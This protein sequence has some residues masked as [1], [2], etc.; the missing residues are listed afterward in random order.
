LQPGDFLI[1]NFIMSVVAEIL[2]ILISQIRLGKD[3]SCL[4]APQDEPASRMIVVIVTDV[5]RYLIR[6]DIAR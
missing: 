5:A 2:L 1:A 4:G 3:I 6:T